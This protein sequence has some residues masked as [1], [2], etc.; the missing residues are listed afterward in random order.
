MAKVDTLR[1][2]ARLVLPG[3]PDPFR[4]IWR[5]L[6]SVHFALGLIGFL[7]LAGLL[8]TLLPQIP[9]P[10]RGNA[11]AEQAWLALQEERFGILTTPFYRLGFFTVF[12]AP[13]FIAGLAVLVVSIAV[14]T[15]NRFPAIWRTVTRPPERVPDTFF[16]SAHH[17]ATFEAPQDP[18]AVE[19]VLRRHRFHVKRFETGQAIYLFADRYPW[20]QFGTF[21]SHLALILLLAGA[22]VSRLGTVQEQHLIA[23]GTSAGVFPLTDP[24]HLQLRVDRFVAKFD[25]AGRPLDYRSYL[26]VI[27]NGQVVKQGET[28]VNDPL[29]YQ[30][31][32]FHQ[33]TYTPDGAALRIRD[34]TTG[35]VV[36]NET[37]LLDSGVPAPVLTL[38]GG[39]GSKLSGGVLPP[40]DHIAVQG[41]LVWGR[42]I[43][44]PVQE[45][46]RLFLGLHS[47]DE[48]AARKFSKRSWE[49]LVFEL[50]E[51]GV[52]PPQRLVPGQTTTAGG[53]RLDFHAAVQIPALEVNSLPGI[54]GA[55]LLEM[56]PAG[57]GEGSLTLLSEDQPPLELRP[58]TSVTVGNLEYT[59]EG[60]R[61]FT[62]ITIRRDPGTGLVWVAVALLLLGL[63]ITFYVP[64][65]RL[66]V[67]LTGERLAFAGL[68]GIMVNFTREMQRLAAEA[69]SPDARSALSQP[70]WR[71]EGAAENVL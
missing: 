17:H 11:A 43:A 63:G 4:Q 20:A 44:S 37:L 49:L 55:V 23:E 7:V 54:S 58:G 64:R 33:S 22:L 66:W 52:A 38:Q 71:E 25:E 60:Q 65:R 48:T 28:T 31:F 18:T 59:F 50:T 69:G 57:P 24:R 47:P 61:S 6:T 46:V 56:V 41:R 12:A 67:K 19:R 26:T 45:G 8:G 5:L 29:S 42:T 68:A 13:W 34:L 2:G 27:K 51:T 62:G 36:Y 3:R 32:R 30:G 35:N 15:V 40:T 9:A 21:I 53:L 39:D 70:D 16:T 14:C 10:M 1:E